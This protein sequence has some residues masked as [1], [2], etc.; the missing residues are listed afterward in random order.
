MIREWQLIGNYL[1]VIATYSRYYSGI[2]MDVVRKTMNKSFRI[3]VF[4]QDLI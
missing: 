2:F 3:G 4:S 1:V